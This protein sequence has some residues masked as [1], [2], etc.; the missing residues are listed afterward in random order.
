MKQKI[1]FHRQP[2]CSKGPGRT[3]HQWP[4][5]CLAK[6]LTTATEAVSLVTLKVV[7]S[8]LTATC[9]AVVKP[10]MLWRKVDT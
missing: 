7:K 8:T 3:K 4:G 1:A 5:L 6:N 10:S 9:Q 2:P